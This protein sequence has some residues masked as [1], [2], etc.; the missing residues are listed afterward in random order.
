M[1]N[2]VLNFILALALIFAQAQG[3]ASYKEGGVTF[4]TGGAPV[5]F[6]A[7]TP[8]TKVGTPT[9]GTFCTSAATCAA[10]AITIINASDT[11]IVC[12]KWSKNA[13]GGTGFS[14]TGVTSSPS[15]TF[16][17]QTSSRAAKTTATDFNEMGAECA[18]ATAGASG[19]LTPTC[20]FTATP[21]FTWCD[22]IEVTPIS[23]V[24][25][26]AP[27]TGS[28]TTPTA[29]TVTTNFD[30]EFVVV[31]SLFDDGNASHAYSAGSG[32]TLWGASAAGAGLWGAEYFAQTSAG[33]FT[34]AFPTNASVAGG[35][36][37]MLMTVKP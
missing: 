10:P 13:G 24:D 22:A 11:V 9:F 17:V 28:S 34:G 18:T 14:L 16:T 29:G 8:V 36:V 33:S 1:S 35:W 15:N 19:S 6:A 7:F 3:G 32:F 30:G 23:G 25:V 37:L 4:R 2:P 27:T 12:G 5:T 21:D 31:E 26:T 20:A